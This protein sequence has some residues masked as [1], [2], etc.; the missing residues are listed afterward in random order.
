M[1]QQNKPNYSL[2][3]LIRLVAVSDGVLVFGISYYLMTS[4]EGFDL[5]PGI[6]SLALA[7]AVYGGTF[8]FGGLIFAPS[9]KD[10]IVSD[11]TKISGSNV[12]M[13]T[14]LRPSGDPELDRWIKSFTFA[15]NL[16]GMAI[17]PI[18]ILVWVVYT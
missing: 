3:K 16:F 2:L 13:V 17:I 4:F 6:I 8:Y 15:R 5:V 1:N 18:L 14:T 11:D 7:G 12:E 9:L 10:Y